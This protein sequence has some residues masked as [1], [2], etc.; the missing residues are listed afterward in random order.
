MNTITPVRTN[1]PSFGM[2][3][4]VNQ[5]FLDA[6]K[7]LSGSKIKR[8]L[9]QFTTMHNA[10]DAANCDVIF[11]INNLA[12]TI[13]QGKGKK[14]LTKT[15]TKVIAQIESVYD[16]EIV[17]K[18]IAVDI[19]KFGSIFNGFFG[20]IN[21]SINEVSGRQEDLRRFSSFK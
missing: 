18:P 12:K 13:P 20:K 1:S 17:G 7:H 6:I 3:A 14:P 19:R 16:R 8:A 21:N 4:R 11:S 5:D 2:A 9:D 15:T 10:S